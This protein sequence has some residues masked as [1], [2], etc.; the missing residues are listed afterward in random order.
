VKRRAYV[1]WLSCS[2]CGEERTVPLDGDA[3][4]ECPVCGSHELHTELVE[5]VAA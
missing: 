3:A 2:D 1:F 4:L 5:D